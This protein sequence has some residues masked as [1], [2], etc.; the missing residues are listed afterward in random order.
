[1]APVDGASLAFFRVAFG[2]ILTWE[3]VRYFDNGW[4]F[5]YW[6]GPSFHFTYWGFDWVAPW[7]GD[8]M[9]W[10]WRALG[11]LALLITVGLAYRA[12][13]A[14]FFVG[15]AYV[16]LLDKA[17]YL[18]HA[19]L[20]ILLALLLA[21]VPAH[22]TFSLDARFR[23]RVRAAP[24]PAWAIWLLRAQIGLVYFFG[25]I[26]KLNG[27][28]LRGEPLR[29]WLAG[30]PD[31]PLLG[32]LFDDEW[33]VRM[34]TYGGLTLDLLAAPLLLWRRT[35]LFA[36]AALVFFH[37]TNSQLF[38][39][40]I[41]PWLALA[42]TTIFFEPDWPRRLWGFLTGPRRPA[43][44]LAARPAG[45]FSRPLVAFL[46]LYL[47]IQVLMPLRHWVYPGS[48]HWTEEGHRFSWHMK[49]RDK[50]VRELSF[51]AYD[52]ASGERVDVNPAAYL[53]ERQIDKMGGRP[54]MLR[55]FAR[56]VSRELERTRG[57]RYEVRVHALV[58]LNDRRPQLLVDPKADLASAP[59]GP[60]RSA[61]WIMPLR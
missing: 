28:W 8:G 40:G 60:F 54:D 61:A 1:L 3:V 38:S 51:A 49:L 36:F 50:E 21:V 31:F 14:L 53:T 10:H 33:L 6:I 37:V 52:P 30:Q 24:T 48:V 44:P 15:F 11:L 2:L 26:A 39:I 42:A 32:P 20:I 16:F 43:P 17:W 59:D 58:A 45:R 22:R 12:A 41:F 47:G 35:R 13:A 18:N 55:Q 25:G 4:I 27:D 57:R 29:S 9:F 7:P 5:D 19:Y 34:F 46:A 56:H 23:P